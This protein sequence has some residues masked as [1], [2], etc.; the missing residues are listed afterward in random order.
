MKAK[1]LGTAVLAAALALAGCGGKTE[2][3]I[4]GNF[5][6]SGG[7]V[8]GV[9]NAGMELTN[10]NDTITIPVGATSFSFPS[11]IDYGDTYNVVITK[12][13][14]HMTCTPPNTSGT[15]G[16]TE[17]VTIPITCAQNVYSVV[18]TVKG[19]T[20]EGLQLINGSSLAAPTVASPVAEFS[21]IPVGTAYGITIFAQPKGQTCS[22][23]NGSGIMG[24]AHRVDAVVTCVA[25]T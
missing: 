2:F 6:N 15:A 4:G 14:A 3:T 20:G 25:S 11:T 10:G 18:V 7:Y 1:Y 22:I 16:R 21:S 23:V 9:P 17:A 5:Y 24:D 8:T 12:Q 13:P 19:L